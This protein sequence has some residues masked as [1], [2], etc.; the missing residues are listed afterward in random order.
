MAEKSAREREQAQLRLQLQR[1]QLG[2]APPWI[3]GDAGS[4]L[5]ILRAELDQ[6]DLRI[7]PLAKRASEL[8][9]ARWG[10]LMRA[11]SDKSRMARQI[12][13]Y[14]DAYTSRVSNL[15][16]VTPFGYLRSSGGTLPHDP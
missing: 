6:L 10:P 3:E 14:A 15:L 7:A 12:E 13:R 4:R 8:V 2:Y 16:Y 9:N 5:R 1:L 11:G